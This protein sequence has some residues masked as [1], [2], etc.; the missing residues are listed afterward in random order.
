MYVV[1]VEQMRMIEKKAN[2]LG[3]PYEQMMEYAGT[4]MAEFINTRFSMEFEDEE[5]K[6][7]L[8]LIGSGNNGGDALITLRELQTKGWITHAYIVLERTTSDPLIS[9]Y[10]ACGGTVHNHSAD[11]KFAALKKICPSVQFVLDGI[12]GI[13]AHLPLDET[14]KSVLKTVS[15][16]E[17]GMVNLAVDCPTG[18]DCVSGEV[19]PETLH[20]DF[21]L[22]MAAVKTGL[23]TFPAFEYCGNFVNISIGVEKIL[24]TFES[25]LCEIITPAKISTLLPLRPLDSHK[26][27]FGTVMVVAGS[28]NYTG[29]VMLAAEAAYRSGAGLVRAAIPGMIH[30]A[31]AGHIPEATWLLLPHAAGV[32]AE[33]AAE[34]I[35]K[36]LGKTTALLVGP[37]IETEETTRHFLKRLLARPGKKGSLGV[38]GFVP[39]DSKEP[40]INGIPVLP[41]LVVDA[42]ALR[43]LADIPEWWKLLPAGSILTPHPGEM[44]ALSGISVQEIQEKRM[45]LALH[46]AKEWKQIVILKGA[47]TVIASP[48][49]KVYLSTFAN[50]SLARAGSGDI[51]AGL[52]TGFLAQGVKPLDA[53]QLG[54][55][56]H[57]SCGELASEDS[58]AA[59]ILARDLINQIPVCVRVL[60][61]LTY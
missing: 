50:P 9:T 34:L 31:I 41:P 15:K 23:L 20:F 58:D 5:N 22:S 54:V 45:E 7:I 37:G 16:F 17:E 8:G 6:S 1:S 2:E 61:E 44:A 3:V 38:I 46:F 12:L 33:S 27:T 11:P 48:D 47:L 24:P 19:A 55:W 59:T 40:E 51:L 29:A 39:T 43:I 28:I 57:G 25:E 26:G 36:S 49:G 10:Q 60:R 18:I 21:T 42:D 52:I 14:I 13:G 35:H 30:T 32:I 53:A 4:G 56:I